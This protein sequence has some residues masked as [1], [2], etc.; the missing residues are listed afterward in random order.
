MPTNF[1][2]NGDAVRTSPYILNLSF[3]G[4]D[5]E[6]VIDAWRDFVAVS[7]G[8]ACASQRNYC[9]H[10]LNAMGINGQ[11]AVGAVRLSWY[12]ASQ[13]PNL[14]ALVGALKSIPA[15]RDERIA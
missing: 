4:L 1:E 2:L 12:Q 11:R 14:T 10:V 13:T 6:Q 15:G 7:N 5:N 9:S 3:P 8:A